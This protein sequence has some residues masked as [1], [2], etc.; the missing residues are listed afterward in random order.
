MGQD[1]ELVFRLL[2]LIEGDVEP[3][4][5]YTADAVGGRPVTE[6]DRHIGMMRDSGLI[7]VGDWSVGG[8][9]WAGQSFLDNAR[10]SPT[11][12]LAS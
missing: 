8:L 4:S 7:R 3:N 1:M 12:R 2:A 10:D 11:L 9:T 5:L 6:I